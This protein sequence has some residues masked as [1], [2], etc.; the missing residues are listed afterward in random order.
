MLIES[1]TVLVFQYFKLF[2]LKLF[3][4][5]SLKLPEPLI[6]KLVA[7]LVLG[8][9]VTFIGNASVDWLFTAPGATE[10]KLIAEG[11]IVTSMVSGRLKKVSNFELG[12][13]CRIY[14]CIIS[15]K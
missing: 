7:T 11:E 8:L 2:R 5:P 15:A 3:E 12:G 10:P 1:A 13:S 4:P 9:I 6:V 14:N